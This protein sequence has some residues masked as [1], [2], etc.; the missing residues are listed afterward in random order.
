MEGLPQAIAHRSGSKT[1]PALF[2]RSPYRQAIQSSP[3]LGK[4]R[5]AN[6]PVYL[7]ASPLTKPWV[8]SRACDHR[9]RQQPIFQESSKAVKKEDFATAAVLQ[10]ISCKYCTMRLP[11][12]NARPVA[13]I[14]IP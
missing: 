9:A 3:S 13:R 2:G 4:N 7:S 1:Q 8:R 11:D 14:Q 12:F 5:L 10:V 6:G